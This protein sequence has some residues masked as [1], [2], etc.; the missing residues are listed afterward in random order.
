M[1]IAIPY[2]SVYMHDCRAHN[3]KCIYT[4]VMQIA[5]PY[6]S[7]YMHDHH[8]HNEKCIY[9]T[10]MQIVIPYGSVYMHDRRIL[11]YLLSIHTTVVHISF[12]QLFTLLCNVI[13]LLI[14]RT[15][16]V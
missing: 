11:T 10:V 3:E 7:V 8:V 5:I 4:T 15:T 9:T 13:F 1:Q 16:I 2:G 14:I 6:G 12:H